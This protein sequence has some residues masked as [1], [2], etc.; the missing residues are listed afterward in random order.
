M[1]PAYFSSVFRQEVG[2]TYIKYL[3]QVRMEKAKQL[4]NEGYKVFEVSQMVG[5]ENYRYFCV[6]F[7]KY[8]GVTAQQYKGVTKN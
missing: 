2:T 3:T 4:L 6:L 5:Y 1:T 7:K 8:T